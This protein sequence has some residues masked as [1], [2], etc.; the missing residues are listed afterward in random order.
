VTPRRSSP[1][2]WAASIHSAVVGAR[3]P[4][5]LTGRAAAEVKYTYLDEIP[6]GANGKYEDFKSE[7]GG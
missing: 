4:A 1:A 2:A 5:I 3:W 6:R 7:I